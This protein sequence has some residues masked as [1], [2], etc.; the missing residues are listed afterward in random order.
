MF[1]TDVYDSRIYAYEHDVLYSFSV[2]A[3]Y[4]RGSRAYLIVTYD[5]GRWSGLTV[6]LA[7]TFYINRDTSGSG[8]NEIDGPTRTEVKAQWRVK[9]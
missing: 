4:Y 5:I 1:D 2:P 3:Y 7:Q 6:R 8:L 9:L